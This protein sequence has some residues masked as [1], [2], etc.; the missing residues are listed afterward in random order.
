MVSTF[1]ELKDEQI[2]PLLN[3]W[4]TK[5]S[6]LDQ[7]FVNAVLEF[8]G[9]LNYLHWFGLKSHVVITYVYISCLLFLCSTD[10]QISGIKEILILDILNR[11]EM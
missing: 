2:Y 1:R 6:C 3:F 10:M 7:S 11:D 4:E 9:S 5:N 8:R